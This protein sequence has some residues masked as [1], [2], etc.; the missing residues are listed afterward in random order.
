MHVM[1]EVRCQD[2]CVLK[3]AKHGEWMGDPAVLLR[4][5]EAEERGGYAHP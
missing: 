5:A 4:K 1:D 2:Q 3:R